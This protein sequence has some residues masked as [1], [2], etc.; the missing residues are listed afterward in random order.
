MKEIREI[1]FSKTS[2]HHR[3]DNRYYVL[4]YILREIHGNVIQILLTMLQKN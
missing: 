2:K 3:L 1:S 4:K